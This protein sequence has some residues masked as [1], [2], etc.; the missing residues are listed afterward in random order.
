MIAP[1]PDEL[2]WIAKLAERFGV[3]LSPHAS[4]VFD[5]VSAVCFGGISYGEIGEQAPLPPRAEAPPQRRRRPADGAAPEGSGLRLLPTGRSSPAP[6]SSARPSSQ[7]QT[8]RR[9][10]RALA[11]PTRA[12]AGSQPATTVTRQL[13]R[14]DASRCARGSRAISPP[15]PCAS[16]SS[17]AADLHAFVE[18]TK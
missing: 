1:C 10:D 3:E 2:A 18:V 14:H 11:A 5:E 7:F 8:P 17:D 9:R 12:P 16:P 6:P 13:E 4:T 15:A